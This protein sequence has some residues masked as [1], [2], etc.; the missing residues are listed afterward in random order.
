M[1]PAVLCAVALWGTHRAQARNRSGSSRAV[2]ALALAWLVVRPAAKIGAVQANTRSASEKVV[3]HPATA[4]G[5]G[6]GMQR[7]NV[8]L[9]ADARVPATPGRLE[10]G[11]D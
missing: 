11:V 3:S 2:V 1:D 9:V 6:V 10:E 4:V 5:V 8:A 7:A